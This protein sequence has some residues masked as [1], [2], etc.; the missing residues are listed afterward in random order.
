MYEF[1]S[2]LVSA[3]RGRGSATHFSDRTNLGIIQKCR[4]IILVKRDFREEL[5]TYDIFRK[6][7]LKPIFIMKFVLKI[8]WNIFLM[9]FII[10]FLSIS[11]LKYLIL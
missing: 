6:H 11:T 2:G 7:T 9:N 4:S 5:E 3:T 10:L 8:F 1:T